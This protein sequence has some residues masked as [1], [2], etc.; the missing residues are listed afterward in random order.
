MEFVGQHDDSFGRFYAGVQ[1]A[2]TDPDTLGLY[3][4]V[5]NILPHDSTWL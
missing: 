1:P 3:A 2:V 5:E 4:V